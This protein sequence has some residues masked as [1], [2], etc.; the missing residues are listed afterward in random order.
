MAREETNKKRKEKEE[1][2]KAAGKELPKKIRYKPGTVALREIRRYQK[3]VDLL[4]PKAPF[5]KLVREMAGTIDNEL[6]FSAQAL[7]GIQEAAESYLIGLFEDTNLCALH[8]KR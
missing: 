3:T 5:Q 4:L 1:E 6:R 2:A 7:L 8:A